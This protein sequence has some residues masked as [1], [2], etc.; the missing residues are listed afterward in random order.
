MKLRINKLTS[1]L[2]T[3]AML[4]TFIPSFTFTAFAADGN[5]ASVTTADGATSYHTDI[6]D[7]IR[8]A[9]NSEGSTLKL[10]NNIDTNTEVTIDS[11]SFT[12]DLNGK[13]WESSSSVYIQSNANITITDSTTTGE[14]TLYGTNSSGATILLFDTAVLNLVGGTLRGAGYVVNMEPTGNPTQSKFVMSGGTLKTDEIEAIPAHGKSVTI[15]GGTIEGEIRYI[16]GEIDLSGHSNPTGILI[17][18]SGTLPE[19]PTIKLPKGYVLLERNS[20]NVVT[21][22]T[23]WTDYIVGKCDHGGEDAVYDNGICDTCGEALET[24]IVAYD[25]D[26]KSATVTVKEAGTYSLIFAN[27]G[28]GNRLDKVDIVEFNF[29]KG[30]NTVPQE[31][32]DFTLST[33]DKVMLWKDMTNLV[34]LCEAYIVK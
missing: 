3:L 12:I 20:N 32:I 18:T 33:D 31:L 22:L 14:G 15:S 16:T 13:T 10:L 19:N 11:G 29:V 23:T 27:Y 5:V 9:Q 21:D 1:W 25:K 2:L 24:V 7:A 8:A 4:M 6:N 30:I 17:Y 26:A 34:P 28:E